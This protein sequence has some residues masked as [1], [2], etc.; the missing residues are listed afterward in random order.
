MANFQLMNSAD[1]QGM[2][3]E[4]GTPSPPRP[5]PRTVAH[6]RFVS[7]LPVLYADEV[8]LALQHLLHIRW[9]LS[10][11]PSRARAVALSPHMLRLNLAAR[12]GP[13]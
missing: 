7:H 2:E 8:P 9:R 5:P 10:W 6:C 4:S 1:V 3:F 13:T 11:P 12:Q